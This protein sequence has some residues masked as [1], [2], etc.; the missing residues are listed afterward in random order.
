[1]NRSKGN[2][3]NLTAVGTGVALCLLFAGCS[4]TESQPGSSTTAGVADTSTDRDFEPEYVGGYPTAE[5]AEAMFEEYDY[6]AAVQFYVW[7][8]AYLT[9]EK[10]A[11]GHG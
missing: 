1:M 3:A 2:A 8:Y 11:L 7:A 9:A 10:H 5:T 6:Q 4:A